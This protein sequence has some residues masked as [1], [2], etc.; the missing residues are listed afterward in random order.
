MTKGPTTVNGPLHTDDAAMDDRAMVAYFP[1][2]AAAQS[3]RQALMDAGIAPGQID[4]AE[5]AADSTLVQ[6]AREPAD[7]GILGRLREAVLP[8]DSQGATR[9]A[10]RNDEALLTLR[11]TREQVEVAV[12]ILKAAKPSHFDADL[13]LWRNAG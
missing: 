3:A 5:H 7:P 1:S 13:E 8:E 4:I 2:P 11:P 12:E 10:I 6:S 9:S